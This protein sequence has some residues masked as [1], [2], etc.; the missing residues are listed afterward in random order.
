MNKVL[1][2]FA[3]P[4]FEQSK[5]NRALLAGVD[6]IEG[7][8]LHDL[9]EEYP[10]FNIDID[11]ERDLLLEHQIMVWHFPFY[12]YGAPAILK[13]WMDVVLEYGWARGSKGN[14]LRGKT[15]CAVL[16]A[17]GTRPVY[18]HGA[19]HRFTIREFLVPFEQS[20]DL[21]KMSYLP[22]FVVHGTHLLTA[23]DLAAQAALYHD[24][25]RRLVREQCHPELLRPYDYINDWL[26]ATEG[27]M[28]L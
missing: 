18:A 22:P 15:A 28:N 13:Q 14:A 7:V 16:T 6:K 19:L 10:D 20:A 2:L 25:L 27:Q 1:I 17:G 21:C 3:H 23:P 9:Y 24:L 8:T 12:M 11:R 4:R 26:S 5:T